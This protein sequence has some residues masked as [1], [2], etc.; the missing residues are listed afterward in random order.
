MFYFRTISRFRENQKPN[1]DNLWQYQPPHHQ[2]QP[3]PPHQVHSGRVHVAV[4]VSRLLRGFFPGK[5]I[6]QGRVKNC[7]QDYTTECSYYKKKVPLS[8]DRIRIILSLVEL[9]NKQ[10]LLFIH[11]WDFLLNIFQNEARFVGDKSTVCFPFSNQELVSFD[12]ELFANVEVVFHDCSRWLLK[13][14]YS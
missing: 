12:V 8:F 6:Y 7:T 10:F 5:I 13:R 4:F 14:S 1:P 3:C 2:S 11:Y 9:F